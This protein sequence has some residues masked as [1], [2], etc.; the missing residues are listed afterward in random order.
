MT[1][2]EKEQQIKKSKNY[3]TILHEQAI[4]DYIKTSESRKRNELYVAIIQ[5]AFHEMIKKIVYRYKF[6]SLPNIDSLIQECESH[7]VTILSKFDESKGSKAFSYFSVITKNWFI[8]KV[9]KN[10]T[11]IMQESQHEDISSLIEHSHLSTVSSYYEDR[12]NKEYL[13]SLWKEISKWECLKLNDNE[14]KVLMAIKILLAQ[15]DAMEII[16]KKSLYV[17]VREIT[18]LNTKQILSSLNKF[19]MLYIEFNDRW[20][21]EDD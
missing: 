7:L 16:N 11:Q 19:R 20:R 13:E 6:F 18:N 10:V 8:H 15:P 14:G 4:I 5:P 1:M 12:T 3:F 2:T 9:K 17:Y 21:N